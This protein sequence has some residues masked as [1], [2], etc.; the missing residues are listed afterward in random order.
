ML[1]CGCNSLH[2]ASALAVACPATDFVTVML[3]KPCMTCTCVVCPDPSRSVVT[4]AAE[5]LQ[6]ARPIVH[7]QQCC[8][9][10]RASTTGVVITGSDT[11][12]LH[13]VKTKRLPSFRLASRGHLARTVPLTAQCCSAQF[14]RPA[15]SCSCA[16]DTTDVNTF[17]LR[18]I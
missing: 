11:Y 14:L 2:L 5:C 12:Q 7:Q 1:L 8:E 15:P 13:R 18:L 9:P 6:V 16:S 10:Y 17:V 3:C 4:T